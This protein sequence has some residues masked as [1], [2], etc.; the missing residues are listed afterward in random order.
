MENVTVA[1]SKWRV[2]GYSLYQSFN[3]HVNLKCFQNKKFG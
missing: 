2:Y 1:E 3:F